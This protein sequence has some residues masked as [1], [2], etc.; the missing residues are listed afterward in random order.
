MAVKKA[1][2]RQERENVFE[3]RWRQRE[4]L[5]RFDSA[6]AIIR[7]IVSRQQ[8]NQEDLKA[9]DAFTFSLSVFLQS[10]WSRQRASPRV[11]SRV[12]RWR[13]PA[14]LPLAECRFPAGPERS[15]PKS[16]QPG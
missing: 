3:R 1:Q 11:L 14:V 9:C 15:T 12:R 4:K 13:V 16:R 5:E 8:F 2:A 10:F 6:T 7:V